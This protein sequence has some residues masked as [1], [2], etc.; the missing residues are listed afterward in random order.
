MNVVHCLHIPFTSLAKM[1][2]ILVLTLIDEHRTI[3][4]CWK[5]LFLRKCIAEILRITES[6][7]EF[8]ISTYNWHGE[9]PNFMLLLLFFI[10]FEFLQ[11]FFRVVTVFHRDV[12]R[13]TWKIF[14]DVLVLKMAHLWPWLTCAV[15][16]NYLQYLYTSV[17]PSLKFT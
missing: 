17:S 11:S 5:V 13:K 8:F 16:I 15:S 10:I 3:N 7:F 14:Q 1:M 4:S 9:S 2:V 6:I 12:T